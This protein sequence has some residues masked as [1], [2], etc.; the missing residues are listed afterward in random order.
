[1]TENQNISVLDLSN[2]DEI[3]LRRA[4]VDFTHATRQCG[5]LYV[6][7]SEGEREIIAA[8]RRQQRLFFQQQLDAKKDIAIDLNNRG[9]LGSGE[10]LMAGA[11]RRDQKEVFFWGREVPADD[12]DILAGVPLCGLNQWPKCLPD[13]KSA[14][15]SYTALVQRTGE[16]LLKIIALSL[17][18]SD[19]FFSKYYERSMLRGQLLRYPTTENHPDQYGVA[20]HSDFGCITLLL[21]ETAGLEVLFPNGE[22]VAAAPL[23]NTLVVNI[24]DL[25]ER[26]SNC[27]L[28]STKHRVRNTSFE[29]RYSIAM[30][31]DP[32]PTAVVNPLELLPD[33][34]ALYPPVAASQYILSR[35]QGAFDHYKKADDSSQII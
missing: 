24:G 11:K 35:N 12:P 27:R 30:F 25:L 13:F 2:P 20:P 28:P 29:S 16:L 8:V 23:E 10:A 1:M 31:Y 7:I 34:A 17:G 26:W 15:T 33:E 22:W 3:D 4:A 32:S 9:Y 18:A 21:Q 19:D 6:R 5:F 14:V